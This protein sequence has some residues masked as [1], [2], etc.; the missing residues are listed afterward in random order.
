VA[1][2]RLFTVPNL[3]S[4][5]RL[6][7]A[8]AF[9]VAEGTPARVALIGAASLTDF[10]DGWLARRGQTTQLG[11][12]LDPVADKTFVLAA[13]SAFLFGGVLSV[14]DYFIILSRDFATAVGFIVA[15][16]LPGLDPR[17]FRARFSGKVVTVLQLA[18]LLVLILR[19]AWLA[20]LVWPIAAA[21]V[22]AIVDYTLLLQRERVRT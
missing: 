6:P 20:W 8:A 22:W 16:L 15:Y 18:A 11:A 13:L 17:R 19:P 5:A 9:V 21:S 10:L 12:L 1:R 7:L 14:R 3:L 4:L 2:S